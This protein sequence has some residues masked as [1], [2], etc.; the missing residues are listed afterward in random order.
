MRGVVALRVVLG[1]LQMPPSSAASSRHVSNM[2]M[3]VSMFMLG[4]SEWC[5]KSTVQSR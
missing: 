1:P 4:P 2:V 3:G 5:V